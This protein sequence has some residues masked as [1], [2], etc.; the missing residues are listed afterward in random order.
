MQ[1][2]KLKKKELKFP[3]NR[4]PEKNSLEKDA[5]DKYAIIS[6]KKNRL[7]AEN[8]HYFIWGYHAVL[9]ALSNPNRVVKTIYASPKSK[10]R[11]LELVQNAVCKTE[12]GPL[13][14]TI[15]E[16]GQFNF[17]SD[18]YDKRVHQHLMIEVKPLEILDL[19]DVLFGNENL[20]L[21]VLD[22]ITD[23]RNIG[24]II[25]SAKA[26]GCDAI[27]IT[28]H[29]APSENGSLAR[30]AAGALEDIPFVTVKNLRRTIETLK[31][32]SICCIG[33]DTSGEKRLEDFTLEP[34]LAIIIGSENAGMRRLT[35]QSCDYIVKIPMKNKTESLNASVASAIALY[36][37]QISANHNSK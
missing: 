28:K 19:S 17:S 26:F 2:K 21:I 27:I 25:R 35:K 3:S 8:G 32:N 11:A 7:S 18:S 24:A 12:S 20:R 30:A 13:K 37:T 29:N 6:H 4:Q 34:R 23:P 31:S 22:Q 10:N 36:V 9:A 15:L 5:I 14:L 1:Q 16:T 33:L